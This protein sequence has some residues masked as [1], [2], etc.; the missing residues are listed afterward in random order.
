MF[1]KLKA[2]RRSTSQ[3]A[4]SNSDPAPDQEDVVNEVENNL[5]ITSNSPRDDEY[6][7]SE[8][9]EAVAEATSAEEGTTGP[10]SAATASPSAAGASPVAGMAS[11]PITADPPSPLSPPDTAYNGSNAGSSRQGGASSAAPSSQRSPPPTS[12][13]SEFQT[14]LRKVTANLVDILDQMSSTGGSVTNSPPGSS[15]DGVLPRRHT[16][17]SRLDSAANIVDLEAQG[18]NLT[19]TTGA[20]EMVPSRHVRRLTTTIVDMLRS[21]TATAGTAAG[22][23]CKEGAEG[24]QHNEGA[25]LLWDTASELSLE[26]DKLSISSGIPSTAGGSSARDSEISAATA[27]LKAQYLPQPDYRGDE[28]RPFYLDRKSTTGGRKSPAAPPLDGGKPDI[29]AEV[30]AEEAADYP[31]PQKLIKQRAINWIGLFIYIMFIMVFI[32]YVSIRAAKTLGL[33]GSLWYGIIVLIIEILGG[34]AMLPY[35]LCLTMRVIE[36]EC[37]AAA[38]RASKGHQG[39]PPTA[40]NYHLRVLI[41]CYKEPL[42]VISKTFM[43]SMYAALPPNCRRTVYLLDDGKDVEKRRFVR[44][45]GLSNAV[46]ISGRKRAKGEMNGKS[47]NINNAMRK[48]YP[49]G[50]TIPLDEVICVFDA[51]QVPNADFFTKTVP[52]LDGGQDVAMVLSP[53]TFYN[54]NHDGDIFNHANVHFWDYTQPGY[55]ALGLISCTGTNFLL[56][57]RAF[58]DAGWF[59]EWTLTE[60]FALG[61]ELKRRGWQCRYVDEYL[62]V[63]EAPD[64][65]RNCFQQ[66]SRWAKGHFQVFFGRGRNPAFGAGSKGLSL[67]MRWMYG[68]VVLSYFS[69]FLATPLLMMVPIIT[70]WFGAFPIV[71]NFWAALSITMYYTATLALMYY[72]RSFAHIKSMWFSS[73]ANAIL[74]FAFL[75]AMYR[76][77]VGRWLSGTI[78]FKVTAKGLQRLNKLPLRDI[79]MTLIWFTFSL[80]TLIFGLVHYFKGGV[81]DTPL[82]ISII[83]MVYNLIPQYLL[84]QYAAYRPRGFFNVVCKIA[85]LLSTAMMILGVV[86]VWVLYPKSY[87]YKGALGSSLYFYDTQRVGTLPNDFRVEWRKSAFES[88]AQTSVY[89]AINPNDTLLAGFDEF[90]FGGSDFYSGG[91]FGQDPYSSNDFGSFGGGSSRGGS[92]FDAFG[93]NPLTSAA[94]RAPIAAALGDTGSTGASRPGASTA[95]PAIGDDPFG[96]RRLLQDQLAAAADPFAAASDPFAPVDPIVA[97]DEMFPPIDAAA[98]DEDPFALVDAAGDAPAPAPAAAGTTGA[99]AADEVPI[100]SPTRITPPVTPND[101]TPGALPAPGSSGPNDRL[102]EGGAAA[103]AGDPFSPLNDPFAPGGSGSFGSSDDPFGFAGTDAASSFG[104]G[105]DAFG[106]PMFEAAELATEDTWDLSGGWI[107]GMTAGNMKATSP[108]AFTTALLAWSYVA[109]P[110]AYDKSGQLAQIRDSVRVGADYLSKVHRVDYE[111][112]TSLLITRVGDVD[113]EILLWYRPEDGAARPAYAVDLNSRTQGGLGP[114]AG[115]DLGGSVAAALAASS[116]VFRSSQEAGDSEYADFLLEKAKEVYAAS[117]PTKGRFTDSDFNMTLLYNSSTIYDDMAWAAGWMYKATQ[118]N[119]YLDDLYD[120][121]VKHLQAEGEITDSKYAFDWD[122]VFWPLNVLMA[123]ETGKGTFKKQSEEFLRSWICANN[124]AQYTRR[125]RAFNP[126]SGSLGST[127]NA[128]MLAFMYSDVIESESPAAAHSY[129]CWGLSQMRYM[130]GGAGRS[131]VVGVGKDPP[132]RTQDRTAACPEPPATCNRVT[133]L[134]SPDPDAHTLLGALVQG[135]GNSDDYLDIR[136]NDASRVGI[137]NNAGFTGA[138]AASVLLPEG[139]WEVCLQQ[140]GIYRSDPVCGDFV[141]V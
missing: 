125:G 27:L 55:D 122:N 7:D 6:V 87:D 83:F 77:T 51:D 111:K 13:G 72:T 85:M 56:R 109:F 50:V 15:Q 116:T 79:W 8:S 94:G 141:A 108:I 91:G 121:Y 73:V 29:D 67:L 35:G 127:S 134:L 60:D 24:G 102:F 114:A 65:V 106:D 46:Y 115:A 63:G 53:Q 124:A 54:L 78:V 41:P 132:Q 30:A 2:A 112:N 133:G 137:E 123:Q 107:A 39:P 75:K 113:T 100:P 23:N 82:A 84:L 5:E 62:A 98:T 97:D 76:A 130:L 68:S 45:L 37:V 120:F 92:A 59:P 86:L 104:G 49:E 140:Y 89:L 95:P 119:A 136:S 1:K 57:S 69:A 12:P 99:G 126:S 101:M 47:A 64:E 96:R 16:M 14:H 38:D 71:I 58:C 22:T 90:G 128:A 34:V 31:I 18:N 52:R 25:A 42:D 10:P 21:M 20:D 36:P 3:P 129:R 66:R 135:P 105:F 11:H 80:V 48:I 32:T 138:L 131:M 43:A 110:G 93:E 4:A 40:I 81:L 19:A 88:E 28:V 44:S 70:V 26:S 74:W 61:I 17:G 117:A 33:G 9:A 139:M 118:D 103:G